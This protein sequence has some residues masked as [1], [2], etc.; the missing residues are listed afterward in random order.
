MDYYFVTNH[1]NELDR[2]NRKDEDAVAKCKD[3]CWYLVLW[4]VV[5]VVLS[6]FQKDGRVWDDDN[7]E[8]NT[9]TDR[10]YED[11]GLYLSI[12]TIFITLHQVTLSMN[13]IKPKLAIPSKIGKRCQDDALDPYQEN[14]TEHGPLLFNFQWGKPIIPSYA[15]CCHSQSGEVSIGWNKDRTGSQK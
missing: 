1:R 15:C 2:I 11:T 9:R 14:E 6:K 3:D 10:V 13:R 4:R 5:I 7:H 12:F 8:W